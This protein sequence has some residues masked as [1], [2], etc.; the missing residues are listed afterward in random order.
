MLRETHQLQTRTN[1]QCAF[2]ATRAKLPAIKLIQMAIIKYLLGRYFQKFLL[3]LGFICI[4][5]I[6]THADIINADSKAP[7]KNG[8]AI[9][10]VCDNAHAY[11]V[12]DILKILDAP[13]SLNSNNIP[14]LS[15]IMPSASRRFQFRVD[16][17]FH[18]ASTNTHAPL[19][20]TIL[21]AAAKGKGLAILIKTTNGMPIAYCSD[22]VFVAVD[23]K[24]HRG[25]VY[26]S[27]GKFFL[28]VSYQGKGDRV[29]IN[30]Y[31]YV[32]PVVSD[33]D[34]DFNLGGILE[35]LDQQSGTTVS[36]NNGAF[37][38]KTRRGS[39]IILKL[40]TAVDKRS[41]GLNEMAMSNQISFV[42]FYD[43]K[44][45]LDSEQK[46]V[47]VTQQK[48]HRLG[49]PLRKLTTKEYETFDGDFPRSGFPSGYDKEASDG[50]SSLFK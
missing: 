48:I 14:R 17:S 19:P 23:Q 32:D 2:W 45:N 35:A 37:E 46:L 4:A 39:T 1:V 24:Y 31:H 22:G 28:R 20:A 38:I 41:F 29:G 40:H 21:V 18:G 49:I 15:T 8:E 25:L 30:F 3:L 16:I 26:Y 42:R 10:D 9:G 5:Q 36:K 13:S 7:H 50:L 6:Q 43:F 33:C 44:L 12:N 47:G 34:I 27:G 11:S